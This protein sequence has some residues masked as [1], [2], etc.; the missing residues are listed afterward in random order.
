MIF[1]EYGDPHGSLVFYFHG[2]PGGA[3]EAAMF[4][5]IAKNFNVKLICFERSSIDT[6]ILEENY[7]NELSSQAQRLTQGQSFYCIGFSIGTYIALEV[8]RRLQNQVN[9]LH[10][11]SAAAPISSKTLKDR[12]NLLKRMAG[13]SVFRLALDKP[14][15][16]RLLTATQG[17][18]ARNFPQ[19]LLELLF[20][21]ATTNDKK[22]RKTTPFKQ[23]VSEAI[24]EAFSQNSDGYIR[25]INLYTHWNPTPY[26]VP[27]PI[28]FWHGDND[29]WAPSD[30][31]T[32]LIGT[33]D[34]DINVH[35]MKDLSHYSCLISAIPQL[36][37]GTSTPKETES[38]N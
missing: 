16:F 6:R 24:T 33:L 7:F 32:S 11:V 38:M 29:N 25:D 12:D 21:S 19:V 28:H 36:L 22:L 1:E 20:L 10:L 14:R 3:K 23:H 37:L 35:Q 2:A 34:G 9:Q 18:L 27:Y 8:S 30:M 17:L 15:L 31:L 5:D 4:D 13:G 26:K